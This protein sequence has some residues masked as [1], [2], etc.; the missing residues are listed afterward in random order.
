MPLLRL[1]RKRKT[2]QPPDL[3]ALAPEPLVDEIAAEER[4]LI[5]LR[6]RQLSITALPRGYKVLEVKD[7]YLPWARVIIARNPETGDIRYFV[8]EVPLNPRE[9]RLLAKIMDALYWHLRPPPPG[10]DPREFFE[11]EARRIV[12]MFRLQL[13]PTPTVSWGKILYYVTRETIGYGPID[14]LMRDPDVEDI[15]C[16]GVGKPIYVWV[17]PYEYVPT[18]IVF[19]DEEELDEFIAKLAHKA[20]KH[21]SVA[22][23]IVDAILPGGHRLAATYKKEVSTG[24]ST[25]T[26]R[27]FREDPIT[28]V[29]L[30]RWNTLSPEL[31]A[32]LWIVVE[33]KLT[34]LILGVTGSGKT[35]TLNA[36]ATMLRPTTKVVTIE[37][38]PELKLPLE[39][40][41]QLVSRPSYGLGPEKI[42]EVSLFDLV[43]LSL[44]YRPDVII[45]GEV[46]GEEAYVLF[47]AMATGH[48]GMTT[49]HAEDIEA[50]V[51]RLTSPP[52]NIPPS[53]IPLANMALLIRRVRLETG[54]VARRITAVWEIR[55]YGVYFKVAEWNPR[56]DTFKLRIKDSSLLRSIA[57]MHGKDYDWILEE[58]ERRTTVLRWM[59]ERG[60]RA[61]RDVALQVQ[62]YYA[63]P[64]R[65]YRQARDELEAEKGGEGENQAG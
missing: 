62:R 5:K 34:G 29:D 65:V 30:I 40:W 7:V 21:I 42:G 63:N 46:R 19:E 11:K 50:A 41:V 6:S 9:K 49:M 58:H 15:S 55:D 16:V 45:V 59:A 8:D 61:Y 4:E 20:G 57:E 24:G 56:N 13:G 54:M 35:S 47:Q 2:E 28:I 37:D 27:K 25:F 26:I 36:L 3:T 51:K 33:N 31:A 14:P 22:F 1:R 48:G 32:Y 52:M 12:G 10:V 64:E 60:L 43:K 17:R 53:Y 44:R 39:N 23:P 18:N 38:T